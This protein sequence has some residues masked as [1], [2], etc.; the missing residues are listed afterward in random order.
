MATTNLEIFSQA[1]AQLNFLLLSQR[2]MVLVGAFAVTL[3]TF[4]ET[5]KYHYIRYTALLLFIYG[6]AS[7]TKAVID[8]NFFMEDAINDA[9][10]NAQERELL[11]RWQEWSDYSYFMLAIIGFILLNVLII[12]GKE[13]ANWSFGWTKIKKSKK[14]N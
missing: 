2:N 14:I 13:L 7:G 5:F 1:S 11:K 10:T 8:F 6:I 3:Q 4:S 9:N 12:E